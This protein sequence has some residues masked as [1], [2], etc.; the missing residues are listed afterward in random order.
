MDELLR[1]FINE[2]REL[3]EDA[4]KGFL[5]V[6]EDPSD[7]DTINALFRAM[8][9]IKGSSGIFE[10]LSPLTEAV[11][12]GEDLLDEV[13]EG[14]IELTPEIID[15]FLDLLDQLNAW[16]DEIEDSGALGEDAP[17]ISEEYKKR[18]R[19][20]IGE[21]KEETDTTGE[22][23]IEGHDRDEPPPWLER[24][25]DEI[26]QHIFMEGRNVLAISYLPDENCFFTGDDPV[27][28]VKSTPSLMWCEVF[29]KEEIPSREEF[30]PFIC[31]V[32][33][34][35]LTGV[36]K[37]EALQHYLYVEDQIEIAT[38]SPETLA[39]PIG[40]KEG[41]DML[42]PFAQ[43][44]RNL[45]EGG[46]WEEVSDK[47]EIALEITAPGN[48]GYSCL[49][50]IKL[51]I[52]RGED[53][54][55]LVSSFVEA[56]L[57]GR[58]EVKERVSSTLPEEKKE[59]AETSPDKEG[60][61]RPSSQD[62]PL[63]LELLHT[64][65]KILEVPT[66]EDIEEGRKASIKEVC[67]KV[68][69]FL[70]R[71][72]VFRE[73]E[74]SLE[75][76]EVDISHL[77][78]L[79]DEVER[80]FSL[81]PGAPEEKSLPKD[82]E[83]VSSRKQ[84]IKTHHPP[85]TEIKVLKVDQ[86]KIDTLMELVSELVVA[87]NSLPYLARR[88]EEVFGNREMSKDLK[89]QYATI[90]RICEDLQNA[91]MQ[92]RMVPVSHTFQRFP[93]LVRDL[94]RK[95]NKK[96][97]LVLEGEDTRADKTVIEDLAEPLVHLIRNSIDHGIEMPEDRKAKGKPEKGTIVLR[98]LQLEDQILI[99]VED[100]GRGISI[101]KVKQKAYEKGLVSEEELDK[102][103]EEQALQLLFAPGFSTAEQVSDL[104]GRGVGMDVVR[105]MVENL[106]GS[107]KIISR[108]G[109]GTTVQLALPLSMAVTRVLMVE[110]NNELFG[111]PIE[112]VAETVK[113]P[114]E[115]VKFVKRRE[116]IVLRDRLVPIYYL[117]DILGLNGN[118]D[119]D[120][121]IE[122]EV[123]ILIIQLKSSEFGIVV[124]KFHE[125]IDIVL[126]PLEGIMEKYTLYSGATLLGDGRV[127]LVLNPK[128]MVKWL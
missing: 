60:P 30:D 31:K 127:L 22:E 59:P 53:V 58:F 49:S 111:V 15:L 96:I 12:A 2:S 5:K 118:G 33:F 38:L 105:T 109:K 57:T 82:K 66:E 41:L 97:N 120:T 112:N 21:K 84:Q 99:E 25:P 34:R 55:P 1:E 101:E 4:S 89:I 92:I 93:R 110:A 6:E 3:I 73:I 36:S 63:A 52:S 44:A 108:E 8:H 79:V 50:W 71:D 10:F 29:F 26:R 87:K 9:T 114:R 43:E 86:G 103:S 80:S 83:K 45:I 20:L 61:Q 128:E 75:M 65:L 28:L 14:N 24:I 40:D 39:F 68:L 94:S 62:I 67:Q 123:A 64:Q 18:L 85:K 51:L 91:V 88:A 81:S 115:E 37:E 46:R 74:K 90:N 27:L 11:H 95:L 98:A 107:V 42:I 76:D 56:I 17:Q 117:K 77:R 104:S 122:D 13:R 113:I 35:L 70:G 48:F 125:G 72:D 16:L 69:A 32:G 100:D 119:K 54:L 116:T 126:K 121:A 106:G 124:D 78:A 23:V 47:I 102:L 7:K 19:S